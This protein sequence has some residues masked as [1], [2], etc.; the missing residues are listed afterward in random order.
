[1]RGQNQTENVEATTTTTKENGA[2]PGKD[3]KKCFQNYLFFLSI[4]EVVR[5]LNLDVSVH[6]A[7]AVQMRQG[8]Q[9]EHHHHAGFLFVVHRLL[10]DAVKELPALRKVAIPTMKARVESWKKS[11]AD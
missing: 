4:L 10:R 5:V 6:D 11:G 1:M 7:V 2:N 3:E 9:Q 8:R